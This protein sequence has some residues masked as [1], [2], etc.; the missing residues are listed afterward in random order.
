MELY[1]VCC[2]ACISVWKSRDENF[3]LFFFLER[4][5]ITVFKRTQYWPL[6]WPSRIL[7]TPLC[8]SFQGSVQTISFKLYSSQQ[9]FKLKIWYVYLTSLMS[10]TFSVP[11]FFLDLLWFGLIWLCHDLVWSDCATIW[12]GLTVPRFGLVWLCHDLVW[13]DCATIWYGLTLPRFDAMSTS[14]VAGKHISN[15]LW[16]KN[17]KL[18]HLK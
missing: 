12:F 1:I 3:P 4:S 8:S 9:F 5:V 10:F 15:S 6:F 18:F 14:A 7:S 11:V 13:S 2:A 16:V 17:G